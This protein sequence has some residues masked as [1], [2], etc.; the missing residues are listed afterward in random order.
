MYNIIIVAKS[1]LTSPV[2]R[3]VQ[4]DLYL[5]RQCVKIDIKSW[6]V[7]FT[8]F[9]ELH[10][11]RNIPL[12]LKLSFA[13]YKLHDRSTYRTRI[14]HSRPDQLISVSLRG[15]YGSLASSVRDMGCRAWQKICDIRTVLES[16]TR[17]HLTYNASLVRKTFVFSVVNFK[18]MLLVPSNCNKIEWKQQCR[19][20]VIYS[21]LAC[22][23]R[24]L[25]K[26]DFGE[27]LGS[28]L[29]QE[30]LTESNGYLLPDWCMIRFCVS[31]ISKKGTEWPQIN[32]DISE[33]ECASYTIYTGPWGADFHVGWFSR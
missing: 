29:Y 11:W 21:P 7:K 18:E 22:H 10:E 4:I 23:Q 9:T 6:S 17:G 15:F 8:M 19:I 2:F 24:A 25:L 3:I 16:A 30:F 20:F 31:Q 5:M 14:G 13:L 28:T 27:D 1:G 26:Q 12:Q 32:L 33:V